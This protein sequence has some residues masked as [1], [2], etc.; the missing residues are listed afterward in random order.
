MVMSGN[1]GLSSPRTSPIVIRDRAGSAFKAPPIVAATSLSPGAGRSALRRVAQD[2]Q[3]QLADLD[4]VAA[5]QARLVDP[6]PVDVEAVEAADVADG[7]RVALTGELGV[8]AGDGDVV[9][10]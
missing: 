6:L 5:G 8:P 10:E 9:Q 4:L 2:H 3:P 1:S 7:E